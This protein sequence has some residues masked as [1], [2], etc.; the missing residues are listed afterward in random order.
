MADF[1]AVL[2]ALA[3]VV[4]PMALAWWLLGRTPRGNRSTTGSR[5]NMPSK[6][7]R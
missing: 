3:A 1:W 4:L 6:E 5:G 7:D 2:G